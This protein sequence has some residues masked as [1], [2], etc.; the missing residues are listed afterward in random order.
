MAEVLTNPILP[1]IF[2]F[3]R[4]VD[5]DAANP[6]DV[7][8]GGGAYPFPPVAATTTAV[9]AAATDTPGGTGVSKIEVQGVDADFNYAVERIDLAGLTPVTLQTQFFRVFRAIGLVAGSSET[10]DGD[11]SVSVDG[12]VVALILAGNGQ[13]AMAIFTVPIG[14]PAVVRQAY[15]FF[16]AGPAGASA[17]MRFLSRAP[18]GPWN[19]AFLV[20]MDINNP[21]FFHP[22]QGQTSEDAPP[23]TDIRV[24]VDVSANNT[25]VAAGFELEMIRRG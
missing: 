1:R 4:N 15:G 14:Q 23:R 24:E 2:K 9:S 21:H 17:V 8:D 5:I 18:G 6:E 10:N 7:W 3:G 13:T 19:L 22:L 12:T 25:D 20:V 11:I 16:E